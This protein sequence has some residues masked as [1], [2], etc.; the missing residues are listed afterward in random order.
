[1]KILCPAALLILMAGCAAPHS[2][3]ANDAHAPAPA[4]AVELKGDA[5]RSAL[6]GRQLSSVTADGK[7]FTETYS[8]DGIATITISGSAAQKGSWQINEGVMCVNYAAY[9]QECNTI[10]ADDQWVWLIDSTKMT[11]NNRFSRH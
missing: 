8:P 9:G 10:K 5:I 2:G 7:P 3:P 6:V 11:T 4:S 1:M